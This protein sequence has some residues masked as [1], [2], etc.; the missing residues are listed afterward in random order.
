MRAAGLGFLLVEFVP[1][2]DDR[3]CSYITHLDESGEPAFHFTTRVI[4]RQPPGM[5]DAVYRVAEH[6]P[7]LAAHA[8]RLF[9]Q[10]G[11]RGLAN[12]EFKLDARDGGPKLIECNARF[13]TSNGLIQAS[14][15]D[16]ARWVY[17]RLVGLPQQVPR[18]FRSGLRMWDPVKDFASYRELAR[19]GELTFTGWVRTLRPARPFWFRWYDPMPSVEYWGYAARRAVRRRLR[20]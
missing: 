1:G 3:Y 14:G 18:E 8:L 16:L 13:T 9:R 7:G 11:L 15:L 10:V 5:G 12:V 19:R 20:S 4:R 6:V 2:P 17:R